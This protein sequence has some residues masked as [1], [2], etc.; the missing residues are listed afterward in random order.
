[1]KSKGVKDVNVNFAKPCAGCKMRQQTVSVGKSK[2]LE[3]AEKI[4]AAVARRH[5]NCHQ[6][7]PAPAPNPE[8]AFLQSQA[9]IE[10]LERELTKQRQRAFNFERDCG[11]LKRKFNESEHAVNELRK[12]KGLKTWHDNKRCAIDPANRTPFGVGVRS[13]KMRGERGTGIEEL[14]EVHC[15]G[16]E[17]KLLDV[18]YAIIGKYHLQ[19]QV[20]GHF[21]ITVDATNAYIVGRAKAALKELKHCRS[22]TQRQQY[23]LVLTVLAPES[24]LRKAEPVADALGVGRQ[25]KPFLDA[26]QMR[27]EVDRLI[28]AS[29]KQLQVGDE[30]LCRHGKGTLVE[31]DSDYDSEDGSC[32]K[33]CAVEIEISGHR[34][35]SKFKRTGK[36]KGGARLQR[37]PISFA[38]GSRKLREDATSAEVEKQVMLHVSDPLFSCSDLVLAVQI[39][40]SRL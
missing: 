18:V 32:D 17:A 40:W 13:A 25:G 7:V 6:T 1:M 3:K 39:D 29:E 38:H 30:V 20:K 21:G 8:A 31:V 34:Q 5:E 22:E 26:I 19:A 27:A 23:R 10:R 15:E 24:G 37:V 9:E 35:V 36:G 14:L 28:K 33:P 2:G 16:S 4:G 11:M 12:A